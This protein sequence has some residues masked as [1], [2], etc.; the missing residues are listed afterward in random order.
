MNL[1]PEQQA[2]LDGAKL[3]MEG[4]GVADGA[5]TYHGHKWDNMSGSE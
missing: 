5:L 3:P 2:L 1:T 4:L